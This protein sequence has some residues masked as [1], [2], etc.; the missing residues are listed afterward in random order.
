MGRSH[1]TEVAMRKTTLAT[2]HTG[3]PIRNTM[4]AIA[5]TLK[6]TRGLVQCFQSREGKG[7]PLAKSENIEAQRKPR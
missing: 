2:P 3:N 7:N 1:A 6:M 4:S 5:C